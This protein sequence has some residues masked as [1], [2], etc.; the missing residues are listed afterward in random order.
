MAAV[1][2]LMKEFLMATA[3]IVTMKELGMWLNQ[4]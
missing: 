3:I 2:I 1:I 4:F